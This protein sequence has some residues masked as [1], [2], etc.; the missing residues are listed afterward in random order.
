LIIAE[1]KYTTVTFD[2]TSITIDRNAPGR[3]GR[4]TYALAQISGV[5][6]SPPR[7]TQ[8]GGR[9]TLVMAGG[10]QRGSRSSTRLSSAGDDPLTVI[11]GK[12]R[13]SQFQALADAITRALAGGPAQPQAVAA[14]A[15]AGLADQLAQL[16]AL[17]DSGALSDAEFAA[18]KARLLGEPAAPQDQPPA[19]QA[20]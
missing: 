1:S 18:A 9:F 17:R 19:G 4:D 12:S 20:W 8:A 5:Q 11:F 15:A 7:L 3:H 2:G 16:A 13:L 10:V 6:L 14:P